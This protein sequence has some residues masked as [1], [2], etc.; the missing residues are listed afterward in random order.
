MSRQHSTLSFGFPDSPVLFQPLQGSL[1]EIKSHLGALPTAGSHHCT[2][3]SAADTARNRGCLA[4][5]AFWAGGRC[6][7]Y[8][9][10]TYLC[11]HQAAFRFFNRFVFFSFYRASLF[12]F[13][14]WTFYIHNALVSDN[15]SVFYLLSKIFSTD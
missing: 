5:G 7:Q 12:C 6:R 9:N 3:S 15:L 10:Q 11:L 2:L 1:L 14:K 13:Y 8:V 4:F